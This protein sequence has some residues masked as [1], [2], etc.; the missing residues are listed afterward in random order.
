M[1]RD[2]FASLLSGDGFQ[3]VKT[4]SREAGF[5]AEHSHPFEAKALILEGQIMIATAGGER[6]YTEGKVFHLLPGVPHTET[7]GPAGVTYLVGR[8]T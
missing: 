1:D 4:V 5:M 7:Y 8:K 6:T 2:E 3:E